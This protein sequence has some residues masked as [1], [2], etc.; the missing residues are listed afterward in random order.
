MLHTFKNPFFLL[1]ICYQIYLLQPTLLL[2]C[3]WNMKL[4]VDMWG[5][6]F[7]VGITCVQSQNGVGTM[8]VTS[9]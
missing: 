3:A 5:G 7:F 9:T 2:A 8:K 1:I 6:S 4:Y